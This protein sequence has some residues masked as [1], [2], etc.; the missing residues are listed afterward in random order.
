MDVE[1]LI[2]NFVLEPIGET[3]LL[4]ITDNRDRVTTAGHFETLGDAQAA[5]NLIHV[6]KLR[7]GLTS[8]ARDKSAVRSDFFIEDFK[9]T[10]ASIFPVEDS[11]SPSEM[12]K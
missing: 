11:V 12:H 3:Y 7:C 5:L 10:I 1:T 8:K 4:V 6:F 9:A 2:Q